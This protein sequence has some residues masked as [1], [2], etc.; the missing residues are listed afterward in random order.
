MQT[1]MNKMRGIILILTR[2][3]FSGLPPEKLQLYQQERCEFGCIPAAGTCHYERTL[4][5]MTMMAGHFLGR[6]CKSYSEYPKSLT[7]I[8]TIPLIETNV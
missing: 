7:F 8:F 4:N 1:A 3:N 5:V 6:S 2:F